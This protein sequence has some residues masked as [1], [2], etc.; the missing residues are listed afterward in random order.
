MPK[1]ASR[2][3]SPNQV[4]FRYK[5]A[6]AAILFLSLLWCSLFVGV[7][8]LTEGGPFSRRVA[9]IITL[10][11]S[12]VCHQTPDR[13][14]HLLGNPLAVCARC[15]GIYGGFLVGV[16]VYP[17]LRKLEGG[18][19]PPR[20]ILGAGVLPTGVEILLSRLRV[21]SPDPLLRGPTGLILGGVVAFYVLPAVFELVDHPKKT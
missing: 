5:T 3:H 1:R 15:T 14:F 10:F 21:I 20:W 7:P 2:N 11:F 9:T 6:Y 13:S 8:F 4:P 18:V 17:F 16:V 12:P 19:R